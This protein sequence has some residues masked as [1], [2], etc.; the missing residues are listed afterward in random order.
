VGLRAGLGRLGEEKV[1]DP[2]GIR[3]ARSQS[4]YR[5]RYPGSSLKHMDIC[6]YLYVTEEHIYSVN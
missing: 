3:P 4:L 5:L 2:A 1:L 6:I